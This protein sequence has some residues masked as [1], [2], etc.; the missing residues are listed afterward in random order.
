MYDDALELEVTDTRTHRTFNTP[1][2][3]TV[4]HLHDLE[5]SDHFPEDYVIKAHQAVNAVELEKSH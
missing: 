3:P 1:S 2:L 5:W 4:I